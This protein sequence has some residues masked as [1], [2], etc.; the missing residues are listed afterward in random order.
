MGFHPHLHEDIDLLVLDPLRTRRGQRRPVLARLA[1]ATYAAQSEEIAAVLTDMMMPIM[2]GPATI[3]VL[4]KMNP[5]V[6]II[7]ASGLSIASHVAQSAS[8]GVQHF[9]PK[10]YTGEA[11]LKV[12]RQVLSGEH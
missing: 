9:L 4:R 2:D 7:G 6:R 12:L 5:A 8:L 1:V 11:L 3:Q 10:P